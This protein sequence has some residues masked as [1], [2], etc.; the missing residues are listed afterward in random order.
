MS[1][2]NPCYPITMTVGQEIL[3]LSVLHR[4][5]AP[6]NS[7]YLNVFG[8]D[9]VQIARYGMHGIDSRGVL[10]YVDSTINRLP[11]S[12]HYEI[13]M[14]GNIVQSGNIIVSN[15]RAALVPQDPS[16]ICQCTGCTS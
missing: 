8:H 9:G 13:E 12:Y 5:T 3:T 15:V 1:D 16:S 14:C 2:F 10:F 4:C 11:T 7:T 6:P